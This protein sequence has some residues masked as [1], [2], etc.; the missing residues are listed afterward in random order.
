MSS[1]GYF[2]PGR[3]RRGLHDQPVHHGAVLA[4]RRE[5]LGRARAAARASSSSFCFVS[6]RSAPLSSAYTSG[7]SRRRSPTSTARLPSAPERHVR[8]PTRRPVVS[9]STAPPAVGDARRRT[10]RGRRSTVKSSA[11]AVG[12]PPDRARHR[13]DRAP[14]SGR[15]GR[16]AGRRDDRQ[17]VQVVGVVLRLV[18]LQ[19][20]DPLA[21]GAP[22]RP[23]AVAAGVR[24][25]LPR[26]APA[27]ASTTKMSVSSVRSGSGRRAC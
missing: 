6:L 17:L 25:Q 9:F 3:E 5:V 23:A 22:R 13:R 7:G 21:V 1:V 19:V 18:A 11:L 15:V 14:R 12:R 16:A 4:R 27:F 24:R 20:G 26:L 10:R 2:L 8:R